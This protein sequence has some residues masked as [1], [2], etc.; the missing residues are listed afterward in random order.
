MVSAVTEVCRRRIGRISYQTPCVTGRFPT[1]PETVGIVHSPMPRRRNCCGVASR[2][3][4]S[5]RVGKRRVSVYRRLE[6]HHLEIPN[7]SNGK[8]FPSGVLQA[9][10]FLRGD[11]GAQ[12]CAA[13]TASSS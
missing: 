11:G 1:R 4:V 7:M 2:K 6:I 9:R 5:G 12:S 10:I 8:H 13:R 3:S